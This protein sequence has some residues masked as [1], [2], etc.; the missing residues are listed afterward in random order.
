VL[1]FVCVTA[2]SLGCWQ[3]PESCESVSSLQTLFDELVQES[4][5]E[6]LAGGRLQAVHRLLAGNE[7]QTERHSVT[8]FRKGTCRLA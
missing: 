4:L 8:G 7:K 5:A 2:V 1:Q 3:P 6:Y